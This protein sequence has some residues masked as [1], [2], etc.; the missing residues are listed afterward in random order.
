MLPQWMK[1]TKEDSVGAQL[2]DVVC[3]Q[4][5]EMDWT[6]RNILL[7]GYGME[8]IASQ[9]EEEPGVD[10]LSI[11]YLYKLNIPPSVMDLTSNTVLGIIDANAQVLQRSVTYYNFYQ[12]EM[13]KYYFD[14]DNYIVYFK[15]PYDSVVI[16]GAEFTEMQPHHVWNPLDEIG[17]LLGCPRISLEKNTDYRTRLLDVYQNPGNSSKTG[18]MNYLSRSL[19]ITREDIDIQSLSDESFIE[20]MINEDGTVKD[21]LKGYM[22]I[23]RKINSM[24]ANTY[25]EAIDE[26][27]AGMSYLPM[28]WDTGLVKWPESEIQNGVGFED[29]LLIR[30]PEH[31]DNVQEFTYSLYAQGLNYPD[32]RIYPEHRFKFRVYATGQQYDSGYR[33]EAYRYTV[34]ASELIRLSFTVAAYA[35]YENEYLMEYD[36]PFVAVGDMIPGNNHDNDYILGGITIKDGTWSPNIGRRYLQVAATLETKDPE[37]TPAVRGITV[38]YREAGVDKTIVIDKKDA[39]SQAGDIYTVGFETNSWND[40]SPVLRVKSDTNDMYNVL[41]HFGNP[42][43]EDNTMTLGQGEYHF[44]YD[45]RGDWDNGVYNPNSKNVR[46]TS[47]GRLRLNN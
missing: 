21:E 11:D 30:G 13:N 40:V 31:E 27:S 17:L 8:P 1:M 14:E 23:S 15:Y 39:L 28:V 29:D 7:S 38:A 24:D 34:T 19:G 36:S 9:E 12:P 16:N 25:W 37:K 44:I 32:K 10:I 20:S 42:D 43:Y 26:S 47:N 6:I 33:P 22:E 18:L 5:N 4:L 2:V 3:T 41:A 35:N 46:S 45:S